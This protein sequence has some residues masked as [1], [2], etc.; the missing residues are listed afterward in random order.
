MKMTKGL[1]AFQLKMIGITLMVL[2]HI[3]QMWMLEGAPN[4]LTMVGRVVAPIFLFLSAEGF[5]YTR[6][7]WGYFKNLLFGYWLMNIISF[8]LPRLVP[9]N[10]VVLMNNIFGTLLIG[11]ILMWIYDL[12][13]EGIKEKQKNKL[14]KGI[15]I[16]V[17]LL[18]YSIII[19]MFMGGNNAIVTLVAISIFPSL[20]AI[21]GG[22]LMAIL[23]LMFYIFR[24]KRLWQFISLAA[25]ALIST[26]FSTT[27]LFLVNIQW[28]MIFAWIP[29]YFYNGT[30]GKKMKYF[31]YLF[32]PA[33][34]VILYL[35]ATL[36]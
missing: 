17:G 21:E 14:F 3:H 13:S 22:F 23:A 10:D 33:H 9:N 28:M 25:V 35:L 27:D 20:F 34:L 19:L 5:H 15:G 11:I 31:F 6:N 36:I 29:I 4:W 2:D 18:A 30:E 26:G 32:Y 24:E 12:I 1:N 16:L 7:R 8:G